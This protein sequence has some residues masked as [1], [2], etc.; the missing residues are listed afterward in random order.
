[1]EAKQEAEQKKVRNKKEQEKEEQ[2]RSA[3]LFADAAKK[4]SKSIELVSR[5]KSMYGAQ[6]TLADQS[7]PA[8][9]PSKKG[10]PQAKRSRDDKTL[11]A[12]TKQIWTWT[13]KTLWTAL[14]A[15]PSSTPMDC[16]NASQAGS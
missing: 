6:G 7:V 10:V 15:P 9:I 11:S 3:H 13:T 4:I 2:V 1:M 12:T 14:K 5:I 16:Q 8:K